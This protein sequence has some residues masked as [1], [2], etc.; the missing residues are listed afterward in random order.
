MKTTEYTAPGIKCGGCAETVTESLKS[1]AGVH[2]VR[3]DV[4]AKQVTVTFYEAVVN[5]EQLRSQLAQAGFPV[6]A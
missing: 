1:I 6:A 5:D 3:V 2:D 4:A